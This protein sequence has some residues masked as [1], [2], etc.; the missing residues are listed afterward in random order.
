MPRHRSLNLKKFIDSIPEPL[1]EEYFKQKVE[2]GASFSL[3]TFD[4]DSV[5]KFLDTIQDEDHKEA[6][7][8]AYDFYCLFNASSKMNLK[9]LLGHK[10]L[11]MTLRYA[12]LAPAHKMQAVKVLDQMS[13]VQKLH[14]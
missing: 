10:T 6:F 9:E 8:Y 1:I 7:D 3:N 13:S 12:H 2:G 14:N 11:T 4:Y 5:N